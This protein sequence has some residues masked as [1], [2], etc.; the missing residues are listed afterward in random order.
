MCGV[1]VA[2]S[3]DV[4]YLISGSVAASYAQACGSSFLRIVP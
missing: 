1:L 3:L 2:V 4:I